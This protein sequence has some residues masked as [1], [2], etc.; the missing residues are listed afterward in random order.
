MQQWTVQISILIHIA[1]IE[2]VCSRHQVSGRRITFEVFRPRPGCN[3]GI[4]RAI[5]VNLGLECLESAFVGHDQGGHS[6][7][8][9][10]FH[11]A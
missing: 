2:A 5:N 8:R 7:L 6:A 1:Q 11:R 3:I 10:C 9:L 4:T